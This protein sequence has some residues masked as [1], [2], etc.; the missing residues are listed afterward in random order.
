MVGRT[1]EGFVE[2]KIPDSV[3]QLIWTYVKDVADEFS[4]LVVDVI[5]AL[6]QF[7]LDFGDLLS[8]GLFDI[9]DE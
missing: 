8:L 7:L 6:G 5:D 1:V 4:R 9:D 3:F 2:D